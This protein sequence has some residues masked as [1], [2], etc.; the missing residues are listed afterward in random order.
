MRPIN[1]NN[2]VAMALIWFIPEMH[3][4]IEGSAA[5][6]PIRSIEVGTAV[7]R[8]SGCGGAADAVMV[9]ATLRRPPGLGL[10]TVFSASS[11]SANGSSLD[12]MYSPCLMLHS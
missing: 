9:A 5:G 10:M 1:E 6:P 4:S 7:A 11:G 8:I 12:M 3:C 2:V